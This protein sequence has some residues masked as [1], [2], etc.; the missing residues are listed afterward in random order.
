MTTQA[1][2][3]WVRPT[4]SGRS[5]GWVP[6][7]L[8]VLVLIPAIFGSLRLIELAVGRLAFSSRLAASI[9]LGFTA[10]RRGDVAL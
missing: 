8:I 10:I 9:I 4:R 7:A 2:T 5:T 1:A 6:F 3:R